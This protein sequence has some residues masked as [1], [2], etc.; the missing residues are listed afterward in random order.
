MISLGW[1]CAIR[2]TLFLD[3]FFSPF[4][5]QLSPI[6]FVGNIRSYSVYARVVGS[7]AFKIL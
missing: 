2:S 7:P 4:F 1:W 3:Q 6:I 5:T